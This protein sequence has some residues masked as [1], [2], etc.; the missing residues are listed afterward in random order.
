MRR[1]FCAFL[2]RDPDHVLL[3]VISRQPSPVKIVVH[4]ISDIF[5]HHLRHILIILLGSLLLPTTILGRPALPGPRPGLEVG[6][7]S[8]RGHVLIE[9][10]VPPPL[11]A[12]SCLEW[13]GPFYWI[14]SIRG[15][16][17]VPLVCIGGGSRVFISGFLMPL[18]WSPP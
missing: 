13:A 2:P 17:A 6:N 18:D 16:V 4:Y 9:I 14:W 5:R 8:L 15:V 1:V 11:T 3:Y 12:L 7:V 10:C